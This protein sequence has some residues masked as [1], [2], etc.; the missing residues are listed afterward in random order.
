MRATVI[1]FTVQEI[2]ALHF[3]MLAQ[4]SRHRTYRVVRDSR[5]VLYVKE[6]NGTMHR[7]TP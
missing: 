3:F 5:H 1:V 6:A 7:M 4:P 2:E